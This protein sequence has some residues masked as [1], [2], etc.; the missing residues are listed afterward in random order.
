MIDKIQAVHPDWCQKTM[1]LVEEKINA[2]TNEN[3]DLGVPESNPTTVKP[4][5]V[6]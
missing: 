3:D 5:D 6:S 4:M 1:A 2:A